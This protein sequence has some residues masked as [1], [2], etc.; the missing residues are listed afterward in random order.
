M[1]LDRY[2]AQLESLCLRTPLQWFNFYDLWH[3]EP[4]TVDPRTPDGNN[5]L[6]HVH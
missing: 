2:A 5:P 1:W 4:T 3:L 6:T